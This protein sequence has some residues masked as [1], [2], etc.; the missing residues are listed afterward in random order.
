M[1]DSVVSDQ[2]PTDV[3]DNRYRRIQFQVLQE[4]AGQ[5]GMIIGER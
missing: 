3:R 2:D 1:Q 5:T 4:L